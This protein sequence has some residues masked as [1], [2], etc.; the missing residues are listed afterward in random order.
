MDT[1]NRQITKMADL[2]EAT[3]DRIIQTGVD[4]AGDSGAIDWEDLLN[5]IERYENVVLPD[6]MDDPVIRKVQR[7]IRNAVREAREG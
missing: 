3:L 2:D 5:R 6:Q 4:W 1:T 7:K